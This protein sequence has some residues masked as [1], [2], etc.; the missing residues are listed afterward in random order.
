MI[1]AMSPSAS[2]AA[3]MLPT[4]GTAP[5]TVFTSSNVM[6][7]PLILRSH[8]SKRLPPCATSFG[9]ISLSQVTAC[10]FSAPGGSC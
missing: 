2:I 4:I 5:A 8:A 7:L 6:W 1:S 10:S 9:E 3:M